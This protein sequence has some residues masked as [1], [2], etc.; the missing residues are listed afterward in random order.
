MEI[1]ACLSL[2]EAIMNV[3]EASATLLAPTKALFGWLKKWLMLMLICCERKI[4]L[5]C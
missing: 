2:F 1:H 4:I 5:F 3:V